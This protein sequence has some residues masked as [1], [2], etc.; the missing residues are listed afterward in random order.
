MRLKTGFHVVLYFFFNTEM[1]QEAYYYKQ[2]VKFSVQFHVEVRPYH[3]FFPTL[4]LNFL[5]YS[6]L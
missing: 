5:G 1:L 4:E 2:K 6:S 3:V